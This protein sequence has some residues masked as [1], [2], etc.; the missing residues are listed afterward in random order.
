MFL[1]FPICLTC[2]TRIVVMSR[3]GKAEGRHQLQG[4]AS[5]LQT[6]SY[7]VRT[8]KKTLRFFNTR[9]YN[10]TVTFLT[11]LPA[12]PRAGEEM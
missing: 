3:D 9:L 12:E 2:R 11:T 7:Q 5:T 6:T 10:L 4:K 1:V 8:E